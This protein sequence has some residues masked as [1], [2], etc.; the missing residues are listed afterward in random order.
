VDLDFP[1]KKLNLFSPDHCAGRILY[2]RTNALAVLPMRITQSGHIYIRVML[3]GESMNALVDTGAGVTIINATTARRRFGLNETS[4]DVERVKSSTLDQDDLFFHRFKSLTM[5]GVAVSNPRVQILPDLMG[6]AMPFNPGSMLPAEERQGL[7]DL[8]IGQS[9]LSNL[10]VYIAYRER[11]L[12]LSEDDP[13]APA[14]L[15]TV[16]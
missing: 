3:D 12:Y 7:P 8:I 15:P 2:W 6:K 5:E 16:Q 14:L 9:V 11:K 10:H 13:Q 4:P 1:R